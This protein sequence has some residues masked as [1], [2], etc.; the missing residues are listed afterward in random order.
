MRILTIKN[1]N[2]IEADIKACLAK[3]AES[4]FLQRLT[5]LQYIIE[6]DQSS[7]S[8][9]E[10]FNVSHR[11]VLNWVNKINETGDIESIRDKPGKGRKTRLTSVQLDQIKK[12]VNAE[13]RMSGIKADSWNGKT[14]AQ[15]ITNNIGTTLQPR[16][17]QRLLAK[18]GS[19]NKPGRPKE[20]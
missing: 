9:A 16:Q 8:A 4:R 6:H 13:P 15:Y 18:L 17:S 5:I 20:T 7:I 2:L 3:T 11:T 12:A 19:A 10:V 14:L 1:K